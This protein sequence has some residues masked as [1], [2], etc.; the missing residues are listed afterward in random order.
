MFKWTQEFVFVY[1]IKYVQFNS[2][3]LIHIIRKK[4]NYINC[5]YETRITHLSSKVYFFISSYNF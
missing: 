4:I 3:E 2:Q 5:I 1:T